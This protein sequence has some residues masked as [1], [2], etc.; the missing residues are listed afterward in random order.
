MELL[1]PYLPH[2]GAAGRL[3]GRGADNAPVALGST[4]PAPEPKLG[5]PQVGTASYSPQDS[6]VVFKHHS[7]HRCCLQQTQTNS[8]NAKEPRKKPHAEKTCSFSPKRLVSLTGFKSLSSQCKFFLGSGEAL[9]PRT[10]T[11]QEGPAHLGNIWMFSHP[12]RVPGAYFFPRKDP[13]KPSFCTHCRLQP[14]LEIHPR[15]WKGRR[16]KHRLG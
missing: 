15:V 1:L 4:T 13:E 8:I 5:T 14:L 12:R 3:D 6:V 2:P 7:L 16:Y 11:P 9:P 10:M